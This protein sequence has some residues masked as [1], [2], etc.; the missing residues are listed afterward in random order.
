MR[1]DF[2]FYSYQCPLNDDMIQLLE[3]YRD[4][5]DIYYHDISEDPETAKNMGMFY[6]T[7]MVLDNNKRYYSPIS[8]SFL[9]QVVKGAY[10]TEKPYMCTLSQQVVAGNIEAI[11]AKNIETACECCE[12]ANISNCRKKA[13][14][15]KQ[16]GDCYGFLNMDDD[17]KMLGGVEFL[18]SEI[19]PYDIPR[20]KHIAFITC[21][22]RSDS[23]YDYKTAPLQAL[24]QHLRGEYSEIIAITDEKG[25]FPNGDLDF[26]I[27]NGY[28]DKGVVFKDKS[29]CTLHLVS[30]QL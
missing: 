19:I 12:N 5:L 18:P 17:G 26:F 15:L 29:Y 10:P 20:G 8:R 28:I 6:P 30:K 23:E 14:F 11:T 24:E 3:K 22:Y 27:R 21:I 4:K 16:Y 25:V 1:L 2:Y 7:L 13:G 9:E